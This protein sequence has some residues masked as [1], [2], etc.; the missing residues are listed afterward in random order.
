MSRKKLENAGAEGEPSALDK[1]P[2]K[3]ENCDGP[4][5]ANVT[6]DADVP[7]VTNVTEDP[8]VAVGEEGDEMC[9]CVCKSKENVRRCGR[10]KISLYCSKEC[11]V[12]HNS[13]HKG[14]C[15][16]MSG[17]AELQDIED[18]KLYGDLS[19]RQKQVDGKTRTKMVKLVGE[20]PMLQCFLDAL[21]FDVLW[22]TGSMVSMV[23]RGWLAEHFPD[24]AVIDVSEFLGRKLSVT[25]A[26]KTVINFDGVVVLRFSLGEG[27]GFLVPVLVSSSE[28]SEPILGYNVIEHLVVKGSEDEHKLL[29]ESLR[30]GDHGVEVDMLVAAMQEK[31][32]DSDYLAPIKAQEDV[33]VPA[34]RKVR[35]RCRVKVPGNG[36][37][38]T[39]YFQP[40]LGDEDEELSFTDSVCRLKYGRT[41]YVYLDVMNQTRRDRVLPKGE[42]IGSVHSVGAVI[43]MVKFL[44][45]EGGVKKAEV[46]EVKVGNDEGSEIET[47]I[48]EQENGKPQWDLSHLDEKQREL[49]EE[50]LERNRDVFSTS[51]S[52]IGDIPDF[53]MPIHLV[54]QQPVNAAY[55]KIPPHLY[56]E[57]KNYVNDLVSN[58]WVRGQHT[59]ARLCAYGK[60]MVR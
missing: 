30:N 16:I 13:Q 58:G 49:M 32:D 56:T 1:T 29:K 54:D 57:V 40:R 48:Q 44:D 52:D 5:V 26:N 4:E 18:T 51:D 6:E 55:R 9:C 24:K 2:I 3:E 43:P 7:E 46:K 19:V 37:D 15:S 47:G 8:N 59:V 42:V 17:M 41:N 14:W 50:M 33:H 60:R 36:G 34:G 45:A 39:V 28:M 22:D 35:I 12:A 20:K 21:G 10:C 31:Y 38:E 53:Q 11:Q 25:A 27:D 23:S